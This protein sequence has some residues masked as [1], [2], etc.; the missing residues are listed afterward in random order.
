MAFGKSSM[1]NRKYTIT[2]DMA[3]LDPDLIGLLLSPFWRRALAMSLDF[4][5]IAIIAIPLLIGLYYAKLRVFNPEL[6]NAVQAVMNNSES[7]GETVLFKK[8]NFEILELIEKEKPDI[9]PPD[10]A[11]PMKSGNDSLLRSAI[12]EYEWEYNISFLTSA[13]GLTKFNY[14]EKTARIGVDAVA[15]NFVSV[16]NISVIFILYFTFFSWFLRGATPGKKLLS[17]RVIRLNGAKLTFYESFER[18]GGYS[19]SIATLGLGFLEAIWHP[20]RQT[21]HDRISSTAVIYMPRER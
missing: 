14:Y 1:D 6:Y 18:A 5:L 15:G 11:D 21:V 13:D 12:D 2:E 20:N 16:L 19:A 9:L 8:L 17:I 3:K 4:T 7:A 10:F